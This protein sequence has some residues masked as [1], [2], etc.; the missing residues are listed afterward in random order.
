MPDPSWKERVKGESW[1]LGDTYHLS[2][3]QGNLLMTPLQVNFM[4]AVFANGGRLC[5]PQVA[6]E[7]A[8]VGQ[9]RALRSPARIFSG[10]KPLPASWRVAQAQ[11][12]QNWRAP[13]A[14]I[15][16][17]RVWAK[18]ASCQEIGLREETIRLVKEGMKEACEPGGTGWPLFK[19]KIKNEKLKIDGEN[20]LDA[21]GGWVEI[22][23]GCKTGT[24]EYGDPRGRTHAWFTVF[25]PFKDPEIVVTVLVEGGGEG[26]SVAA[27][28]AK[29]ILKVWFEKRK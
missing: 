29:E 5:R 27:P 8:E 10:L 6:R 11:S 17:N 22:P 13:R 26:A 1:F 18:E 15:S 23:T 4:T 28:V 14:L 25:A 21:G 19:F 12:W 3:G 24:A 2:I 16:K 9:E 20:F 7:G